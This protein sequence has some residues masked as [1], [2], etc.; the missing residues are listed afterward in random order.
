MK[1]DQVTEQSVSYLTFG[2]GCALTVLICLLAAVACD[3]FTP[4]NFGG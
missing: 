1:P 3:V 4:A 2:I